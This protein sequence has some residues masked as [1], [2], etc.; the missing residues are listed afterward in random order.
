MWRATE[1]VHDWFFGTQK[2]PHNFID[3]FGVDPHPSESVVICRWK[4]SK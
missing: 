4:V 1:A 3:V 2:L